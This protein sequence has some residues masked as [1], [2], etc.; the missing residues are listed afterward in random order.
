MRVGKIID[1]LIE[2]VLKAAEHKIGHGLTKYPDP[3]SC[4]DN[5]NR[6]LRS[7]GILVVCVFFCHFLYC[8]KKK[9]ILH[10]ERKRIAMSAS[11]AYIVRTLPQ[12][13]S[14]CA[15]SKGWKLREYQFL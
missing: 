12:M 11:V 7:A 8:Y 5:T 6:I 9:P 14:F 2:P 4:K 15:V 3:P 13:R 10:R 1:E